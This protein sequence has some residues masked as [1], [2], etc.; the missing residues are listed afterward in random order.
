MKESS[1]FIT[2]IEQIIQSSV[3]V[4][5]CCHTT[6][7]SVFMLYVIAKSQKAPGKMTKKR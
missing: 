7:D 6:A 5:S 3:N 1:C 4:L 2:I